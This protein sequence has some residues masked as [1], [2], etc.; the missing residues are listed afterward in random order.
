MTYLM[1]IYLLHILSQN[2]HI[3]NSEEF[4]FVG[5]SGLIYMFPF[6]SVKCNVK[7]YWFEAHVLYTHTHRHTQHLI[8]LFWFTSNHLI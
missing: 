7:F 8:N 3:Q 2:I 1:I 5:Y 6:W 4:S